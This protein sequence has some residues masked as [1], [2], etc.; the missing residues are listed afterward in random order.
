MLSLFWVL[1]VVEQPTVNANRAMTLTMLN[2][3]RI[4]FIL[5]V[6][7]SFGLIWFQRSFEYKCFL[8]SSFFVSRL[9]LSCHTFVTLRNADAPRPANPIEMRKINERNSGLGFHASDS[10]REAAQ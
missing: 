6:P 7:S 8:I 4:C 9:S 1:L 10:V 3:V 2:E 5:L